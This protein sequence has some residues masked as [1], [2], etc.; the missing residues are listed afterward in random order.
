[1]FVVFTAT[2]TPHALHGRVAALLLLILYQFLHLTVLILKA[3]VTVEY[4]RI[5]NDFW[6]FVPFPYTGIVFGATGTGV[7]AAQAADAE[8]ELALFT[9]CAVGVK[10]SSR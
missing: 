2:F 5:T 10:Q 1:M 8:N 9:A 4:N 6:F 7:V 3:A